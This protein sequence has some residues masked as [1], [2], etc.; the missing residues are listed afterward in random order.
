[1]SIQNSEY[2]ST[3]PFDSIYL[4]PVPKR[5]LDSSNG[6]DIDSLGLIEQIPVDVVSEIK[7]RIDSKPAREKLEYLE[8]W[9][10]KLSKVWGVNF[11]QVTMSRT[12]DLIDDIVRVR[13]PSYA[14]TANLNYAM[15]CEGNR[16]L[17]DFTDRATLV[18][19]D[20]MPMLW[21]SQRNQVKLPERVTGA[22]L[23]FKLAERSQEKGHRIYLYGAA[24]GVAEKTALE[25]QKRF[26][27]CVIAGF[28][29]PPFRTLNAAEMKEQIDIVR[30]AKPDILLVAL[31]QPKGEFWIEDNLTRLGVPLCIQVGASFD[32][33]AGVAKRA[34]KIWQKLGLEWLYRALSDPKRLMPRYFQNGLFLLRSIQQD[35][36]Q[37]IDSDAVQHKH[38]AE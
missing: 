37:W 13:T 28:H 17:R 19:C 14:I 26:P 36:L 4:P 30:R 38:A 20:G 16:R 6:I 12:L 1:M 33:V 7:G 10:I 32:F 5:P 24:A 27:G 23:I 9:N 25:L 8:D 22:D 18:L 29:C 35:L 15:L 3:L 34:P 2:S 31:G 11:H 21:R